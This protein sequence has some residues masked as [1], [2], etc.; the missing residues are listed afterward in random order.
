MGGGGLGGGC[1]C[2]R[3]VFTVM[4]LTVAFSGARG[5][6]KGGVAVAVGRSDLGCGC[7]RGGRS[8]SEGHHVESGPGNSDAL[9][10]GWPC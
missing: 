8:G 1:D 9:C 2:Q 5:R 10:A 4:Q 3:G 7:S 6:A